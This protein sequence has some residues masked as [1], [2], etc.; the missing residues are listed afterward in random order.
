MKPLRIF[1]N[2]DAGGATGGS[3]DAGAATGQAT[4]TAT[5]AN[6]A[7]TSGATLLGGASTGQATGAATTQGATSFAW[8]KEDGALDPAWLDRL[9]GDLKGHAALKAI[10][11]IP[12]L[13][14]SYVETKKLMGTKL[15]APGEGA[16]PEQIASWRKTVGAPDKLEGYYG[17]AK[18]LRPDAVPEGMWDAGNE[19]KFLEIAHKH[20]LPPSAVK[21]IL[22]FYG[23]SIATGL[24]A[25]QAQQQTVLAAEGAKLRA[26]WKTEYDTNLA[27]AARVAQTV[28]LD[29]KTHPTFTD[30]SVVIAFA[31][32]G[33]LFSEDKLVQGQSSGIN[34]SITERIRDITDPKSQSMIARE[35]R[36]EFGT[37]RAL[38][39]QSVYHQLLKSQNQT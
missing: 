2:A 19:K 18:T 37:E 13:A 14:K 24:Q 20:H 31:K 27:L 25:S 28:G 34:G 11:S 17:E 29:P 22:G 10:D 33:K 36:G 8:A 6:G 35:Y 30:S 3:G 1:F 23:E 7:S 4:G 15:E 5:A 38:Q 21:E 26:E 12:N 9:P 16:T 32:L 39:A